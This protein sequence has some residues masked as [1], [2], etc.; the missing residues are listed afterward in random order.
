MLSQNI[1]Q[2]SSSPY[3]SPLWIVPKKINN[4]GIKKWSL[5]V[6]YRKLNESIKT[7]KLPIPHMEAIL[8]KLGK[9][10]YF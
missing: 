3:N 8:D 7:D 2:E 9:A 10:Q 1:I 5:V 4:F 6:D